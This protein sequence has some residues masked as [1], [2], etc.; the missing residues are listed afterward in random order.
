[1]YFEITLLAYIIDR[2]FGEFSF[3][4]HPVIIMGDYIKWFEK[5][6]YSD[7]IFRGALLTMTLLFM[8]YLILHLTLKLLSAWVE[9]QLQIGIL[10]I[11]AST[12]FASK[13]LYDSVKDIIKNPSYIAYL[14]SRDS[15]GLSPSDIN[16]AAIETYAENLNDGVIAPLF[17][18][19]IFGVEGAFVYKAINTLDSMVGYRNERYEKFGK[20]SA[21]LDDVVNYLPARI[22]AILIALL[23]GSKK[24]LFHFYDYGKKHDSPN[25]GHP[26]SAMAL[27][28][29]VRL[30]GDTSYFGK[31]KK[32]A[33]FGEGRKEISTTDIKKSLSLRWRL[34]TV[35]V[36]ILLMGIFYK[37]AIIST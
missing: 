21:I 32:K 19:L 10:G 25:A 17:Y 1:M 34:D 11:I 18:L 2:I 31:I 28:I 29:D 35:M 8:S 4:R 26:I 33:F 27:A 7:S 13:M 12:T 37:L 3:I 16:K 20:F 6:F 30:G 24:A 22:T 14:V 23:M 15:K 5:K 9:P 36:I